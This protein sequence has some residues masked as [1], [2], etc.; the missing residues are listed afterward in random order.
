MWTGW[1]CFCLLFSSFL[2]VWSFSVV[3]QQILFYQNLNF[4]FIYIYVFC[5]VGVM[6]SVTIETVACTRYFYSLM[7]LLTSVLVLSDRLYVNCSHTVVDFTIVS[8][9]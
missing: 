7:I 6:A 8:Y 3:C 4:H 9:A 2:T 1:V 5:F